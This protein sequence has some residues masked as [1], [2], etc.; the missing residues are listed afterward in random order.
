MR[1]TRLALWLLI[2]AGLPVLAGDP[3]R[4]GAVRF[5]FKSGEPV[6]LTRSEV[7]RVAGIRT[8]DPAGP[9]ELQCAVQNLYTLNVFRSV[10]V[11]TGDAAAP[12][13]VFRL[14][15]FPMV[16]GLH[17]EGVR[18]VKRRELARTANVVRRM[19]LTDD[20]SPNI[21]TKIV[22]LYHDQGFLDASAGLKLAP[23]K[24]GDDLTVVV[25]EGRRYRC[26]RPDTEVLDGQLLPEVRVLLGRLVNR[27]YTRQ[28]LDKTQKEIRKLYQDKNYPAIRVEYFIDADPDAATVTP[29]YLLD[30]GPR[31]SVQVEGH[32][33]G[34]E[35][36]QKTL[37]IYRLGDVSPFAEEISRDDLAGFLKN[38]KVPVAAVRSSRR[39]APGG[40]GEEVVFTVEK[41]ERRRVPLRVEGIE[42]FSRR[43]VLR[44]ADVP[45]ELGGTDP[46]VLAPVK[47]RIEKYYQQRGYVDA[48][49][50]FQVVPKHGKDQILAQVSEGTLF[51]LGGVAVN[52]GD[53]AM[54]EGLP[55]LLE[56]ER[57]QPFTADLVEKIRAEVSDRFSAEGY[58]VESIE[59]RQSRRGEL[60]DLDV[61]PRLSGPY[62]LDNVVVIGRFATRPAVMRRLIPL[63]GNRPLDTNSVY[64]A[65]S[66]LYSSGIFESVTIE[67]PSVYGREN[68]RNAIFNLREAPRFTFG[69][70]LGYQEW[71]KVRGMVEINDGNFLGR[72]WNAG[73]L[74]RLSEKKT[75]VQLSFFDEQILL[76][77]YPLSLSIYALQEDQVSY[78]SQQ[79]SIFAQTSKPLSSISTLFFRLGF[80]NIKNYDL[81]ASYDPSELTREEE[82]LTLPSFSTTY[83]RDTRDSLTDPEQGTVSSVSVA[84]APNIFGVHTGFVKLFCQEQYYR[85]V[86][87]SV[88]LAAS[89][90]LG[91]IAPFGGDN[92]VPISERFFA[93]GSNTLRG[94]AVDRAGPLDPE[95]HEPL[96][97]NALVIGNL[98]LRFPIYKMVQGAVFYDVGNVFV[99]FSSA[100]W[101]DI[102]H[103][104]GAGLR[105][106]TP[107]GPI[108]LDFGYS[109]KDLPYDKR[110]QFFITIGNPF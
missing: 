15:A 7:A 1:R 5:E 54:P 40:E 68:A 79:L 87:D 106:K 30:A 17:W 84:V 6:Y 14:D 109:L 19:L 83:L 62:E 50:N 94:F 96:G 22:D 24:Q 33:V 89:F 28:T 9:D 110:D 16:D 20:M 76:D 46:A 101:E 60:V 69:Y 57:G 55:G 63:Q 23:G 3:P 47:G 77:K 37:A 52:P 105:L 64:R 8:G 100:R 26:R 104:V 91:W 70:G 12:E 82:P 11:Y 13:V 98:E 72:G 88:V 95:T 42:V 99:D 85:T 92:P 31:L 39:A 97:G 21:R 86:V 48:L 4:A 90:R 102:S 71:E 38:E 41:G 80:E 34:R 36:L 25:D 51:Q 35:D 66:G 75:L 45:D 67:V 32:R 18:S 65:E 108:R 93:G 78:K 58:L 2:A 43:S 74:F 61:T 56:T 59:V 103:S 73:L 53:A 27:P 10:E 49:V 44:G 81:Q 107:F 29:V